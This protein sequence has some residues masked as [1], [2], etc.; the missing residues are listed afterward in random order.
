MKGLKMAKEIVQIKNTGCDRNTNLTIF[1]FCGPE[2][3]RSMFLISEGL[4]GIQVNKNDIKRLIV[5][6][7]KI[8]S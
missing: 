6:L 7:N 1:S 3:N 4:Q 5:E 8:V 2:N